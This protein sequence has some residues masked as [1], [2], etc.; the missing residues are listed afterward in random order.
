MGWLRE[1]LRTRPG[2]EVSFSEV[3]RLLRK[4]P[5]EWPRQRRL[6]EKSFATYLS[7]F[8][9]H[10][11]LEWLAQNPQFESLLAQFLGLSVEQ[12]R[13]HMGQAAASAASAK[14]SLL[15]LW[16]VDTRPI[17]LREEPLPPAFPA[18]VLDP[19]SWPVLWR[20]P[21]GS[22]RSLVGGWLE[23]RG[24]ARFVRAESWEEASRQLGTLEGPVFIELTSAEGL[25]LSSKD[26]G[27]ICIAVDEAPKSPQP[28]NFAN[29]VWGEVE[30][31]RFEWTQA[32]SPAVELWLE[33]LVR[34]VAERVPST[35]RLDV[36]ACLEWLR[37]ELLPQRVIDRFETALGFIGLFASYHHR[38]P[39]DPKAR[40][41]LKLAD[42]FLRKR[43]LQREAEE[44]PL[45]HKEFL[46]QLQQLSR[47]ML[48]RGERS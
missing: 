37:D 5:F 17:D 34:W 33:P 41:L 4:P 18:E 2:P 48:L 29:V 27:Q 32:S 28:M 13:E 31:S 43:R 35:Q 38:F 11:N 12:L 23:A 14:T 22:G 36:D 9:K 19:G 39:K 21:S 42:F 7:E 8:D 40:S 24:L 3:A 47:Q 44:L 15:S 45:S 10:R 30:A 16:E 6:S 1:L 46:A 20:A 25:P 26:C